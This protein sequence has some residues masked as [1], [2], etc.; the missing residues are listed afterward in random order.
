VGEDLELWLLLSLPILLIIILMVEV[1]KQI[2]R[3]LKRTLA[4]IEELIEQYDRLDST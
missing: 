2:K 4:G 3:E 1:F